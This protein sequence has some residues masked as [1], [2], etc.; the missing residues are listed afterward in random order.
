M[1]NMY[2]IAGCNGA[3]KTTAAYNLLPDTLNCR[4]FVNADEI[5]KGISPFQPEMATYEAG[6]IMLGRIN[7]LIERGTDFAVETTLSALI[8][9]EII[10][11]A[12]SLDYKVSLLYFWLNSTDLAKERVRLRVLEGGHDV[13]GNVIERRYHR[14]LQNLAQIFLPLCDH[15][16]IFDNSELNHKLIMAKI[17]GENEEIYD[18]NIYN[19]I[20]QSYV[21]G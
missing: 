11:K 20:F 8:Y 9:K 19:K 17:K 7:N 6:K 16:M 10:E 15:V 1:K 13:S 12:Q 21:R 4:E 14:G 18:N 2:V 5:A 3:G